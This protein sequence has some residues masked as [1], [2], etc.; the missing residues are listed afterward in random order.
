M[1]K[2]PQSSRGRERVEEVQ[3]LRQIGEARLGKLFKIL[4]AFPRLAIRVFELLYVKR[5][6]VNVSEIALRLGVKNQRRLRYLLE[7]LGDLEIIEKVSTSSNLN[8]YTIGR[9]GLDMYRQIDWYA[10]IPQILPA[11]GKSHSLEVLSY[12]APNAKASWS[13]LRSRLNLSESSL[14]R[15]LG[16]LTAAELVNKTKDGMYSLTQKGKATQ[17]RIA[18]LNT[19]AI[20]PA[21]EVQVKIA[22]HALDEL[23]AKLRNSGLP[24]TERAPRRQEDYY[25]FPTGSD[26]SGAYLR[27]RIE[28]KLD[29]SGRSV[30]APERILSWTQNVSPVLHHGMHIIRR[31]REDMEVPYPAILFILE[32]LDARVKT[33]IVK[34]R[35]TIATEIGPDTLEIN[36]D[37]L[38]T[39]LK[40][41]KHSFI[42]LKTTASSEAEAREKCDEILRLMKLLALQKILTYERAYHE[43]MAEDPR[44]QG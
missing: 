17:N 32:Y 2:R 11:L 26:R 19:L 44:R 1:R 29:K 33:K 23:L 35:R 39:A 42:E 21:Y 4:A 38:E 36:F 28:Q 15:V 40:T 10:W 41:G 6:A 22:V 20:P 8:Y 12:I 7:K 24:L 37:R 9:I 14:A 34:V 27:F 3:R 16:A 25:L 43:L 30:G 31:K 13:Y 5:D 18:Q